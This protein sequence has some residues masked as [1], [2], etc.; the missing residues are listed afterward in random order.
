MTTIKTKTLQER[1]MLV[2]LTISCWTRKVEDR[3][4]AN[5]VETNKKAEHGT[6]G[7]T[8]YLVP[9]SCM[10]KIHSAYLLLRKIHREETLPWRDDGSRILPAK[11]FLDYTQ[12]IRKAKAAYDAAVE[13]FVNE[14]YPTLFKDVQKR[15]GDLYKPDIMPTPAQ[16]KNKFG[17]YTQVFPMP[18]GADFRV[19]LSTEQVKAIQEDIEQQVSSA[20]SMAIT[21]IWEQ[22]GEL[23]AK[24]QETLKDPDKKFKNS[25]V[26]N[27]TSFCKKIPKLNFT[28]DTNLEDMRKHVLN[29]LSKLD[30]EDL[31]TDKTI[32]RKAAK[33][34]EDVMKK[35][36]VFYAK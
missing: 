30:P 17:V 25:T 5:E 10:D 14:K 16:I 29:T 19:K 2:S 28:D 6:V 35:M 9:R 11:N 18:A 7:L 12:K 8:T 27:I 3:Q 15:L 31:R 4:V 1:A 32:R 23:V 24:L 36:S 26:N 33:S 20:T 22:L 13:E 34:A 21:N